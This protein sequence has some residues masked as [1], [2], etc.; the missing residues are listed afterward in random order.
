MKKSVIAISLSIVITTLVYALLVVATTFFEMDNNAL[1]E[2]EKFLV[3]NDKI[4]SQQLI[5]TECK[6]SCPSSA[7]MCIQM[8][9]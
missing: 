2:V 4:Y 6:S 7:E 3:D 9:T 5:E 8:Y 1:G